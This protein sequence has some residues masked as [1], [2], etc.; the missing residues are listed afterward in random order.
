MDGCKGAGARAGCFAGVFGWGENSPDTNN[1]D[2]LAAEFL[3]ELAD[4]A[5]LDLVEGLEEAVWDVDEDGFS[6]GGNVDLSGACD[7]EIAE[8]A[9]QLGVSCFQI[10][11]SL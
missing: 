3:L 4:E 8:V 6:G 10:E 1:D 5:L 7:V 2:I 11:K 9:F